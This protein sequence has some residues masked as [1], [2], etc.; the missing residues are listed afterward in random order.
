MSYRGS[1]SQNDSKAILNEL[2]RAIRKLYTTV[3]TVEA[4]SGAKSTQKHFDDATGEL[5]YCY[6]VQNISKFITKRC[7]KLPDDNPFKQKDLVTLRSITNSHEFIKISQGIGKKMLVSAY[8]HPVYL[9]WLQ[10]KEL[11]LTK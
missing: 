3:P 1:L 4:E 9:Q 2:P 5:V 6:S 11:I 8:R 10:V 7:E